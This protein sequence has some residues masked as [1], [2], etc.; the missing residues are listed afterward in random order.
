MQYKTQAACLSAGLQIHCVLAQVT[1]SPYCSAWWDTALTA[2]AGAGRKEPPESEARW[3]EPSSPASLTTPYRSHLRP[4]P[5]APLQHRAFS[6]LTEKKGETTETPCQQTLTAIQ[7]QMF[8]FPWSGHLE[9][10]LGMRTCNPRAQE[11]PKF[12]ASLVCTTN[13]RP[14]RA[15]LWDSVVELDEGAPAKKILQR[16]AQNPNLVVRK[17]KEDISYHQNVLPVRQTLPPSRH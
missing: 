6:V 8:D 5:P 9:L 3:R 12:K 10:G 1:E 7:D 14:N 11:A 4:R 2:R 13:L 15:T 17:K 16:V